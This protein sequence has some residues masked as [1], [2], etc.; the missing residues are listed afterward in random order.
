VE[1]AG[2]ADLEQSGLASPGDGTIQLS[3]V[4]EAA[5]AGKAINKA[6]KAFEKCIMSAGGSA[7]LPHGEHDSWQAKELI[8]LLEAQVKQL[9]SI[10]A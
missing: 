2:N 9:D 8:R 10:A 6:R 4:V 1:F 5:D 7:R 3:T